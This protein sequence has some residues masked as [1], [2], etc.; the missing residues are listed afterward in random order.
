M[1]TPNQNQPIC[2]NGHK[3]S[4]ATSRFCIYCGTSLTNQAANQPIQPA[5]PQPVQQPPVAVPPPTANQ[6]VQNYQNKP[7]QPPHPN[8][9]Q[10]PQ[11]V[12]TPPIKS[13]NPPPIQ[14]NQGIQPP[15]Y[16]QQVYRQEIYQQQIYQQQVFQ[17]PIPVC[18][19]CGGE[20]KNLEEKQL[21]CQDCQ[22]L[23]PLAP[24]YGIEPGA[25]QW[26]EDGKAMSVLRSITPLTMAAQV[27][28]DKVGRRWI[29]TTFNGVL[30]S[31]KQLPEVYFQ[32][33]K[34]ARILGM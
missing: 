1:T 32:P 27:I 34:V 9:V 23:R 33:V 17:Q 10:P 11:V 12:P 7:V 20:G 8:P 26:A 31:E 19:T 28:S 22:W 6:N 16:Q 21:V 5:Q 14:Q 2:R 13:N 25:F 29:E 30:L 4:N 18:Q 24:G 3:Q 15:V